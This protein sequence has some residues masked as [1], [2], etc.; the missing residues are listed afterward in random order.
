MLF[1][2]DALRELSRILITGSKNKNLNNITVTEVRITSDLSFMT[3]FFMPL[4][5][6]QKD[7]SLKNL[8]LA[9]GYLRSALAK[10]LNARHMPELIFKYDE[11]L[12][13]G[14]HINEILTKID[15]PKEE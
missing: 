3:V 11:A 5:P 9:K 14:N 12:E 6:E 13:Y 2:S 8:E 4:K 10:K 15:L 1:R 7:A